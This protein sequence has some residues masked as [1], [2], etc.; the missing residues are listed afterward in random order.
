MKQTTQQKRKPDSAK[1]AGT[2]ATVPEWAT[3]TPDA[4]YYQLV[5]WRGDGNTA[6]TVEMTRDEYITLK[7]HLAK[8]RG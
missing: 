1:P 5:M 8:Q 7:K 4:D 2:P 3:E 6:E